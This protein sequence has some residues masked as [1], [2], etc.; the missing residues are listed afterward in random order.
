MK[1]FMLT[2]FCIKLHLYVC[3]NMC[4]VYIYI[5]TYILKVLDVWNRGELMQENNSIQN[6]SRVEFSLSIRKFSIALHCLYQI[7]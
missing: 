1:A 3:I 2:H 6:N 4:Y 5:D 7:T